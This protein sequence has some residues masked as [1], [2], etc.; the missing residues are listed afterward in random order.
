[1]SKQKTLLKMLYLQVDVGDKPNNYYI[2]K[3]TLADKNLVLEYINTDYPILNLN[4]ID[5][6]PPIKDKP[7][8]SYDNGYKLNDPTSAITGKYTEGIITTELNLKY[9]YLAFM[10]TPNKLSSAQDL[11]QNVEISFEKSNTGVIEYNI[12]NKRD[13]KAIPDG[14]LTI[15]NNKGELKF[16]ES[17]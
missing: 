3:D 6:N 4:L 17:D 11:S 15:S 10:L 12:N 16:N 7:Y 2:L 1:M 14:G 9:D 8:I 5:K 13:Y